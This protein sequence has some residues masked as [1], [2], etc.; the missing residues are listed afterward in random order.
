M[1][2]SDNRFLSFYGN[3]HKEF[4]FKELYSN[5]INTLKTEFYYAILQCLIAIFYR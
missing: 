4:F 5:R 1:L 3:W 2:V